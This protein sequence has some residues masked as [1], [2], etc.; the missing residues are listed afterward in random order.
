MVLFNKAALLYSL[1]CW[2]TM[3]MHVQLAKDNWEECGE[4]MYGW[5]LSK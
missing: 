2:S 5:L 1:G 3:S 4:E